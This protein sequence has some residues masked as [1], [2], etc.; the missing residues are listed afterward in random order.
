MVTLGEYLETEVLTSESCRRR[1]LLGARPASENDTRV[2]EGH[3]QTSTLSWGH[4]A[5]GGSAEG[6]DVPNCD[7]RARQDAECK[8]LEVVA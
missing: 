3:R 8:K 6:G 4:Q 1:R 2:R 5:E 7:T